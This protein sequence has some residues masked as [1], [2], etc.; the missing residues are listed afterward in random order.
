MNTQM[1]ERALFLPVDGQA[2]CFQSL[3]RWGEQ[4]SCA[5]SVQLTYN[6][7]VALKEV[8]VRVLGLKSTCDVGW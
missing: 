2:G 7:G 3:R 6:S 8:R 4:H 1:A 5:F